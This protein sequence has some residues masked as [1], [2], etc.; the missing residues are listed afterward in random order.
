MNEAHSSICVLDFGGLIKNN[1]MQNRIDILYVLLWMR[2]M[3]FVIKSFKSMNKSRKNETQSSNN[4][5]FKC[6]KFLL[7]SGKLANVSANKKR[8]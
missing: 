5:V 3:H 8:E 4:F 1:F 2:E 7:Q 6:R